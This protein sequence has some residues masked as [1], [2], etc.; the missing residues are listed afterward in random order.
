MINISTSKAVFKT[1]LLLSLFWTSSLF[2]NYQYS[3][4]AITF[5]KT[6]VKM[7][8]MGDELYDKTGVSTVIVARSTLNK[9]EFLSLKSKYLK[10]LKAPYVLWMFAREYTDGERTGK[11]NILIPSDDVKGKYDED[12][13]FSPLRGTFM[14][15]IVDQKKGVDPTAAAFLNGYGDLVDMLSKSYNVTLKSSI[16]NS[17]RDSINVMRILFYSVLL[18]FL[19]WYMKIRFFKKDKNA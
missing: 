18:F 15:L 16:G 1:A 14:K 9:E 10:E 7:K 19:L 11:L 8:E 2:A 4:D 5:D 17:S 12:A 6:V 3:G 13:M